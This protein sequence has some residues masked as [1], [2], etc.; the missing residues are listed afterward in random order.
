MSILG[1]F[2]SSRNLRI[3]ISGYLASFMQKAK[4]IFSSQLS[5]LP[6]KKTTFSLP[7]SSTRSSRS[8][9]QS[10][11]GK[12]PRL[13]RTR[14]VY[15]FPMSGNELHSLLF[16]YA[17]TLAEERSNTVAK[18]TSSTSNPEDEPKTQIPEPVAED[19]TLSSDAI[20]AQPDTDIGSKVQESDISGL[21]QVATP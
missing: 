13:S 18:E 9:Q 16:H 10:V 5:L 12:C 15:T 17:W 1:N 3:K 8:S 14:C 4:Q 6:Q 19:S 7:E 21:S 2:K 11:I 20:L